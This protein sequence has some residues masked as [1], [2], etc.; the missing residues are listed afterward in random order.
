MFH[1]LWSALFGAPDDDSHDTTPPDSK[2][3]DAYELGQRI[4]RSD[5]S[6]DRVWSEE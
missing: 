6:Q 4:D 1:T 2:P 5:R 3:R